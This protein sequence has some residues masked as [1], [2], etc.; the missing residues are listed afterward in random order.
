MILLGSLYDVALLTLK[1]E[2]AAKPALPMPQIMFVV[3]RMWLNVINRFD[4]CEQQK[5]ID[6]TGSPRPH[7]PPLSSQ[8][9]A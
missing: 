4:K 9:R 1:I 6:I 5:P 8:R 7:T 3:E 2:A